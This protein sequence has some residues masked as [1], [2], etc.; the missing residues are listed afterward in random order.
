MSKREKWH[1]IYSNL[2]GTPIIYAVMSLLLFAVTVWGDLK[3]E[4]G[5]MMPSIITA[6]FQLTN[7]ILSTLTGGLLSLTSFTFYGVLTAL[8]TF[9]IQFSPRIL[10]NFMMTNGTQRTLG[11]FT[12]SFLYVL[13]C[14]LFLDGGSATQYCLI[15]VTATVLAA[16]SLGAFVYFINHIVTWLQVTNMGDEMKRE[17]INAI[18]HSLLRD[19]EPYRVGDHDTIK[20][21]LPK[22]QGRQIGID[23]SGYLQTVDFVSLIDEAIKDDLIIRLEFKVGNFIFDSTPLLTYWKKDKA[24]T[25]DEF[26]YKEMFHIG[27]DQTEIQDIEFSIDKFVEIAVRA[28]GNDDIKTATGFIYQIGDLLINISRKANFT[29][30]LTDKDDKL[31]VILQ[32]LNFEDYLYISFASIRH[33]AR[34]NVVITVE[35]LKVLDAI[36]QGVNE[37]DYKA[38]WEFAV[39][40]A[41]GFEYEYMHDLD[42]R[43]YYNAL[44]NI[45]ETTGN[46]QNYKTL[47][48]EISHRPES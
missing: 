10:K 1:Q 32:N 30:Y 3:M 29:P 14:L 25:I 42:K 21:Q 37:R 47:I 43:K 23:F 34:D 5:N 48:E 9:S 28:L 41:R 12:G 27:K 22:D 45:A 35:L 44:L 26:K 4:F 33:Y 46:K 40:T 39:Y 7:T 11:I 8:T 18:E 36:A 15:P 31:R 19:L 17:S 2:W 38:V 24:T 13:L 20:G 6:E 16:L